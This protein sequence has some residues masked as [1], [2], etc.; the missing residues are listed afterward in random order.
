[1]IALLVITDGRRDLIVETI[2]SARANLVGP[3]TRR[4]IYD[5]SG[6]EASR[7]WLRET[8]PDFELIFHPAGRQGFGGA[9][10]TAWSHLALGPERFVFHLEDDFTFNCPVHLWHVANVLDAFPYLTQVALRR[11]PWSDAEVLAG[12]V[13]EQHPEDFI[14]RRSGEL[15]W[16]EHR[17]FFTTNPSL[18]RTELCRRGWPTG[19]Q[20]EGRFSAELFTDPDVRCA[21][22]GARDDEP[23]VHHNGKER[24]GV[25]Y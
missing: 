4:V 24:V 7:A 3:I 15:A 5:D 2:A 8:F 1:V 14:E 12:G 6:D 22:W 13:V 9:I 23:W 11:Q 16:L 17:R 25:G 19:D 10:R 21:Y 18:Y 20:S